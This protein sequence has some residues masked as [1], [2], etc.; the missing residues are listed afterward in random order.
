MRQIARD[1]FARHTLMRT[2]VRMLARGQSCSWCG[3][4]RRSRR[5]RTTSLFR[6]G[7][8]ADAVHPRVAWH[9][10]LFCSKPCHDAYHG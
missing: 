2:V 5:S 8:E 9:D 1:P 10:G 4:V 7:T 3:G 6:Y